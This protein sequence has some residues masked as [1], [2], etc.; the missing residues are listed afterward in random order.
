[1]KNIS[2]FLL[3]LLI[4]APSS[5]GIYAQD[6]LT[7]QDII[8]NVQNAYKDIT[9]AKASFSQT[10]KFSKSKAQTSSGS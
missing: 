3:I 5:G 2:F 9:D 10:I 7:A 6:D 1:M 4:F 8:Q